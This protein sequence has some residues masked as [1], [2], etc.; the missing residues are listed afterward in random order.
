MHVVHELIHVR[1]LIEHVL[2][3]DEEKRS[4]N[5]E[6]KNWCYKSYNNKHI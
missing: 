3:V 4:N 1:M 5:E 6:N 2:Y